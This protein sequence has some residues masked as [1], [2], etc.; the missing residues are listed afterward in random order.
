MIYT[1][2]ELYDVSKILSDVGGFSKAMGFIFGIAISY[3]L[4]S[5]FKKQLGD[6]MGHLDGNREDRLDQLSSDLSY[7][8]LS[9]IQSRLN[10]QALRIS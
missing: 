10:A 2:L 5:K 1:K 3:W 6:S 9:M 8:T 7:D 4:K